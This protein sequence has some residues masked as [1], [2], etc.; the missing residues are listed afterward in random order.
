MKNVQFH[1]FVVFSSRFQ[2]K[3]VTFFFSPLNFITSV[4]EYIFFVNY[5]TVRKQIMLIVSMSQK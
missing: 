2:Q 1:K 5:R 4:P 3:K